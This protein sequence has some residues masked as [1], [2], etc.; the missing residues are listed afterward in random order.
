MT[1]K[2]APRRRSDDKSS[3]TITAR[4]IFWKS[5]DYWKSTRMKLLSR[6]SPCFITGTLPKYPLSSTQVPTTLEWVG[7]YM[8]KSNCKYSR[9]E[10]YRVPTAKVGLDPRPRKK[11]AV[12]HIHCIHPPPP[13]PAPQIHHPC[14]Y[15]SL[16]CSISIMLET[17][18]YKE[19][20][21]ARQL[22]S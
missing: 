13:T 22:V 8:V 6:F 5:I 2:Y 10:A 4:I 16:R 20:K 15:Y 21:V 12:H 3:W 17:L 11:H 7:R 9:L 1:S 14:H 19:R 18:V